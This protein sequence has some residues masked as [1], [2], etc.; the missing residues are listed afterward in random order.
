MK[1]EKLSKTVYSNIP[2]P[3]MIQKEKNKD[4]NKID[5]NKN[6]SKDKN[7]LKQKIDNPSNNKNKKKNNSLKKDNLM[8]VKHKT[9]SNIN[10]SY[11]NKTP[12]LLIKHR[13]SSKLKINKLNVQ[14]NKN[15]SKI[16]TNQVNKNY[17]NSFIKAS[18][19]NKDYNNKNNN[20]NNAYNN[21]IYFFINNKININYQIKQLSYDFKYKYA[22]NILYNE[23]IIHNDN[24]RNNSCPFLLFNYNNKNII[25]KRFNKK[26]FMTQKV[27]KKEIFKKI[28]D[29]S[30]LIKQ[31]NIK[32]KNN[33][34]N[35]DISGL[36]SSFVNKNNKSISKTKTEGK[37]L[38]NKKKKIYLYSSKLSSS[39]N[40]NYYNENS[41]SFFKKKKDIRIE[42]EPNKENLTIIEEN[43]KFKNKF[44]NNLHRYLQNTVSTKNKIVLKEEK[45]VS[46]FNNKNN[47][48]KNLVDKP[49]SLEKRKRYSFINRN[50]FKYIKISNIKDNNITHIIKTKDN[51]KNK[52]QSTEKK[53]NKYQI[54]DFSLKTNNIKIFNGK[55]D[56]YLI[57]KELGKGS[58]ATVKLAI[59]KN[60][61]NKYAIK[62]YERETLI[63]PQKKDYKKWNQY[64]KA[65]R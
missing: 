15:V 47:T 59:N 41:S 37:P 22:N 65:I 30:F 35:K 53:H 10:N 9:S 23:K 7:L 38:T 8:L 62:L 49:K 32:N 2:N 12:S 18:F 43:G 14:N 57:T 56:N 61:K 63:D 27:L 4:N 20:E 19:W 21:I 29:P 16:S 31:N 1:N 26:R 46:N 52:I 17:H 5:K 48:E 50:I 55:I 24:K 42:T 13:K 25:P 54:T 3:H 60:D 34:N 45:K 39:K 11:S 33:K 51:L 36:Y 28:N 58:Y 64:F 44:Y 6:K 40:I